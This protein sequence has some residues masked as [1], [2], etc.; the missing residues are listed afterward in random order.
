MEPTPPSRLQATSK[1]FEL[2]VEIETKMIT[3][4][5]GIGLNVILTEAVKC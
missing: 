1:K 5:D 4:M 3:L 2:I